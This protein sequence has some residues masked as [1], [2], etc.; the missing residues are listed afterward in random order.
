[1]KVGIYGDTGMVGK[2]LDRTLAHHDKAEVIFRQNS[3]RSE[4]DVSDCD[5]AFL[6]TRDPESMAFAPEALDAGARVIDMAGAYRLPQ[7]EFEAW[8]NLKHETPDLLRDAVYG[9][10]ALYADQIARARLVANP[11][12][13]PTSVIL[14]L[15][16][17][18]NLVGGPAVVVATSGNSGAR[19]EVEE[20]S[21]ECTY[22]YGRRHKHVPEMER[23]SGFGVSFTPIV[24]RS[25]FAGINA[26]IRVALSEELRT[27]PVAEAEARLREAISSAYQEE[28]LV[29][30]VVDDADRQWGTREA[31]ATHKLLVK[32][33][34]DEGYAYICSLMDN[35]GKGAASQGIEN[36]NLMAGLPRLYGIGG[37][38]STT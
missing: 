23:Y 38:Y 35:L 37:T 12:C 33:N 15:R 25:V 6:A 16:P 14:P 21:N 30:V 8:Y 3:K 9:M 22:S 36:M 1:V 2:E 24:I 10:P 28:D 7:E 5:V 31:V 4:G 19:S 34:V 32:L 13:Y 11:G 17:L 26:N 27:A 18:R 20:T 29:Q